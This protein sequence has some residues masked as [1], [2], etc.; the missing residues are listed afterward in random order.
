MLKNIASLFT[1]V[2]LTACGGGGGSSEPVVETNYTPPPTPTP[3]YPEPASFAD[4]AA[5]P[6]KVFCP[7]LVPEMRAEA[8]QE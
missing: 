7:Q 6:G 4:D 2:I 1:L 8:L 5:F 3:T